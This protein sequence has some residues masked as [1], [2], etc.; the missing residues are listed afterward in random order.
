MDDGPIWATDNSQIIA[1]KLKRMGR[2]TGCPAPPDRL[3]QEADASGFGKMYAAFDGGI[4][5]L[6]ACTAGD[7]LF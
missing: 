4:S 7:G 5:G 3:Q 1:D 2:L 6:E